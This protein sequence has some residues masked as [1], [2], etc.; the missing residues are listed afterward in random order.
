MG[1]NQ[2]KMLSMFLCNM[3]GYIKNLPVVENCG[4]N[5]WNLED[6]IFFSW[7]LFCGTW[8][9]TVVRW[10]VH[11]EVLLLCLLDIGGVYYAQISGRL[12]LKNLMFSSHSRSNVFVILTLER[13]SRSKTYP[14]L[15]QKNSGTERLFSCLPSSYVVIFALYCVAYLLKSQ[16][17]PWATENSYS[18][19]DKLIWEV[20]T[21]DFKNELPGFLGHSHPCIVFQPSSHMTSQ[22]WLLHL[23]RSLSYHLVVC[24]LTRSI[25]YLGHFSTWLCFV[26][27]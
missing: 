4:I 24:C 22:V 16:W 19:G 17:F 10:S 9:T 26:S 11:L 20:V 15:I 3:F 23:V 27:L 13:N 12:E 2:Y 14:H 25:T 8:L 6:W 7:A 18:Q 21:S 5:S 1:T